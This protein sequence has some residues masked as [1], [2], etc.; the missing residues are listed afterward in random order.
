MGRDSGALILQPVV[1]EW[2][3]EQYA[4]TS[5]WLKEKD[6]TVRRVDPPAQ[7]PVS[8]LARVGDW[9][10][11][12]VQGVIQSPTLRA[13]G[14]DGADIWGGREGGLSNRWRARQW[15]CF[16]GWKETRDP[17]DTRHLYKINLFF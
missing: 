11:P 5:K 2:L 13:D 16:G 1:A 4:L 3:R 15:C 9:R 12:S 8:Y 17:R 7:A 14:T 6:D 10:V